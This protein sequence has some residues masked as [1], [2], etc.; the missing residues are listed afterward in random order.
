MDLCQFWFLRPAVPVPPQGPAGA[1]HADTDHGGEDTR[2]C[3]APL[4]SID[5]EAAALLIIRTS[6]LHRITVNGSRR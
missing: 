3:E 5:L 1:L 4:V 2:T 6:R